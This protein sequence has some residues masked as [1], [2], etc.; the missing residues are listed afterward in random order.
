METKAID[1]L[2]LFFDAA[3]Q[4]AAGLIGAACEKSAQVIHDCWGLDTPEDCRVYVMTS[5]V[6][7][8]FHAPPWSWRVLVAATL[9]LWYFRARKL[10]AL[11][12]GWHQQFGERRAVGVKPPRLLR[13]ADTSIGERIFIKEDDLDERVRR[14]T[15]HELTHAF[16]SHLGLP[17]WLNEGLAMMTVD[18]FA[19]KSTIRSKTIHT[20]A[21][22][23][24]DT[25]P[26]RYRQLRGEA[27]N[28]LVFYHCVRGYW[29]T[30]YLEDTQP[31][32]LEDLLR[33]KHNHGALESKV[34]AAS[35]I[36]PGKFWK[37]ID[38]I[39]VSHFKKKELSTGGENDH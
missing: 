37:S 1:G 27:M 7:F 14:N 3:E 24:K 30:R 38:G 8:L 2:T 20:L 11:A 5:W 34:A 23:P 15:C 18:K 22:P 31:D 33:Q 39:I 16:T 6:R 13:T 25:S 4:D 17:M 10:W 26:G 29:L 21:Q 19:G 9:P 36:E 28:D 32:L 12:G 35:G